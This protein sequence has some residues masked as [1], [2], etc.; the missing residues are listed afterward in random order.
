VGRA[1]QR[2]PKHLL[3]PG[4]LRDAEVGRKENE[5]VLHELQ[6]FAVSQ[7]DKYKACL[8][9]KARVK[10]LRAWV[11]NAAKLRLLYRTDRCK[12]AVHGRWKN[13]FTLR[14]C[15]R[16]GRCWTMLKLQMKFY[17]SRQCWKAS[18]T[19]TVTW[20]LNSQDNLLVHLKFNSPILLLAFVT[21][22]TEQV[23][24]E[25]VQVS[26]KNSS[27]VVLLDSWTDLDALLIIPFWNISF[28]HFA[29]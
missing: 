18:H 11:H 10:L 19:M 3:Q 17:C 26:F 13:L 5:E 12:V 4:K 25:T 8:R 16:L 27:V 2:A 14:I 23:V 1:Y 24:G 15:A 29:E 9:C 28:L 20:L 6:I 22:A 21:N 7:I